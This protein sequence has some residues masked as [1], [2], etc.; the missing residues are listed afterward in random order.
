MRP[1]P[2]SSRR[3]TALGTCSIRTTRCGAC[4]A[5]RSWRSATALSKSAMRWWLGATRSC[6]RPALRRVDNPRPQEHDGFM[7]GEDPRL[8]RPTEE[9]RQRRRNAHERAA[10]AHERAAATHKRAAELYDH[11]GDRE[12]AARERADARDE[13]AE[14]Q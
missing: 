13:L 7:S 5:R 3:C 12:R 4:R 6:G 8:M 11:L 2:R 1:G 9:H 10:A 14:A